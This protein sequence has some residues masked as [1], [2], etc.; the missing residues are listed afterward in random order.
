MRQR[1]EDLWDITLGHIFQ[2]INIYFFCDF[3]VLLAVCV[4]LDYKSSYL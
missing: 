2:N 4:L 1:A 3:V